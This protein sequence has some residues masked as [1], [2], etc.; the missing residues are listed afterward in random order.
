[1]SYTK[2]AVKGV[3]ILFVFN[4]IAAFLGYLIRIVLARNLTV[5]EYGL[6]F[7]VLTLINFLVLFKDVGLCQALV[8]YIP[9]Y[10]VKK[11]PAKISSAIIF[12]F[13]I[14][15]I[16]TAVM[17]VLIIIFAQY[18]SIHYFKEPLAYKVLL[19]FIAILFLTNFRELLRSIFQGFQ[20]MAIYGLMYFAENMLLLIML[21]IGFTLVKDIFTAIYLHILVY[22]LI[23]IGFFFVF[24]KIFNIFKYRSP[25]KK[26]LRKKLFAFGVPTTLGSIGGMIIL[27]IDILILTYFRSLAEVGIYNVVVP[28]AMMLN[29]FAISINIAIFPL[30]SELWARK[31][32][33][34][35]RQ[36]VNLLQKYSLI[37]ILPVALIMFSFSF[38]ILQ[39]F[40]GPDYI[41]GT[42]AFQ[43][44]L[45]GI[46]FLIL[47]QIHLFVIAA[48]GKPK[49]GAK[50]MFIAAGVNIV[51]NFIFIPLLGMLGAAI[52]S[53]LSYFL[54]M[55]LSSFSL[56]K[57]I[58]VKIPWLSWLKTVIAGAFLL[59]TVFIL[60]ETLNVNPLPEAI[61]CIISGVAIYI[62]VIFL[63]KLV[64]LKEI[65]SLLP[66]QISR[67][68]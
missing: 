57:L 44:L 16:I 37:I 43:Y 63:F 39:L 35:I 31:K 7:A 41:S 27:Y 12:T 54:V 6:F 61:I 47:G 38:L 3:S 50:I 5:A 42:L 30:I 62:G 28:T 56:S 9:E 68:F 64:D 52:T 23:V 14:Q 60:K 22:T 21:I 40:F 4:I 8:K 48:V 32:N 29:F 13:V 20:R 24:F 53:L 46:V 2:K 33:K 49:I 10:L 66:S 36:G 15:L 17:A 65:K 45:I 19:I 25:I 26:D 18:L 51:T 55:L 11:T 34:L 59:I 67:F 58:K 1:M